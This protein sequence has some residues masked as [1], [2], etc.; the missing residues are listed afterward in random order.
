MRHS[1]ADRHR[2]L[3]DLIGQID[4]SS[5]RGRAAFDRIHLDAN[6]KVWAACRGNAAEATAYLTAH[7]AETDPRETVSESVAPLH[8][9]AVAY[10]LLG[11]QL[12][13]ASIRKSLPASQLDGVLEREP[14]IEAWR[15][16]LSRL[17]RCS[18]PDEQVERIVDDSG[19][20]FDIF[21][22]STQETLS[23]MMDDAV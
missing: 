9:D 8:P 5:I 20:V 18:P 1:T 19:R 16:F 11:S 22:A 14:D 10:V 23:S 7:M 12:G 6:R 21:L 3:D 2:R 4:L 15:K 17:E 13:L